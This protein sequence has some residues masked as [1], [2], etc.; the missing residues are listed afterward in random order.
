MTN[1]TAPDDS[2]AAGRRSNVSIEQAKQALDAANAASIDRS[3]GRSV[4]AL[5]TAGFGVLVGA[6]FAL[7]KGEWLGSSAVASAGYI[8]IACALAGWQTRAARAVPKGARVIGR[9]GLGLTLVAMIVALGLVN[10]RFRDSP[11]PSWLLPAAGLLVATPLLVA[12]L[13]IQRRTR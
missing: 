1:P 11:A 8:V 9:W 5:G 10:S 12:A 13:V 4:Y 7:S 6:Y 2:H 3:E